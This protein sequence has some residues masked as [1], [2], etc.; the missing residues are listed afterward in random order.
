[1]D[2]DAVS[3]FLLLQEHPVNVLGPS[4]LPAL[5]HP[6]PHLEARVGRDRMSGGA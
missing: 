2:G 5:T 1:M 6:V 3:D 4:C